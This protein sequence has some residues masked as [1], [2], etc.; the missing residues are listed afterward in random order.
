MP[1]KT[2][3]RSIKALIFDFDGL[4]L[5]TEVPDYSAWQEIFHDYG[6]E[7]PLSVWSE[8]VGRAGNFF[9]PIDHLQRLEEVAMVP[10]LEKHLGRP[11]EPEALLARQR[12]R[13]QELIEAETVLPGIEDY[14]KEARRAG[15]KLGIAS[16]SKREWVEGHLERLNLR[17]GWDCL[18]CWGEV[19][20]AKPHPDLY[21]AAL[22]ALEVQS[23]EAIAFEDSP[24]GVRAARE[25]GIFCVAVPNPL[26]AQLDLGGA[27][28]VLKS[29][30]EVAL[31]ELLGRIGERRLHVRN[32]T[33]TP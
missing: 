31:T 11:L 7:L 17:D 8:C 26:T 19:E 25:A 10:Q 22:A 32:P 21:L 16:S 6:H 14:I 20:R 13:H 33:V 5:D 15:L 3:T 18:S 23:E 24:N 12:A 4:I 28:I 9:D 29:L 1:S 27:D 2:K 30:Q